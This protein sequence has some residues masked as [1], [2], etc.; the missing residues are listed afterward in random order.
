MGA[1]KST[2]G[3]QLA[4]RLSFAFVDTDHMIE[5]RT[6]ANIPWIFD[7]EGEE[8]FRQRETAALKSLEGMTKHVIATG[9]GIIEREVNHP[10]LKSLGKVV[11][12]SASLEQLY[13][14]TAKDSKRPLLQVADPKAK[15]KSLVERR[16]PIYKSVA[17]V[18][19]YTDGRN[20]QW[21]VNKI[22]TIFK[23]KKPRLMQP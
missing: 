10:I 4:S 23:Q 7:V 15:I 3:R 17:D 22:V 18:I 21:V 6:G 16:D 1:G 19:L 11:Y 9:G 20:S 8:G 5:A 13:T 12:L 14:R 2:V